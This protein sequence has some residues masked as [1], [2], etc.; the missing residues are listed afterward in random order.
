MIFVEK[1]QAEERGVTVVLLCW[2]GCWS[3]RYCADVADV[4]KQDSVADARGRH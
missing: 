3:T 1:P 4:A 2:Q